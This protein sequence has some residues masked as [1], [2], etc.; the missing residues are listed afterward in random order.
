MFASAHKLPVKVHLE[1]LPRKLPVK[2][3]LG[4]LPPSSIYNIAYIHNFSIIH[5]FFLS[6]SLLQMKVIFHKKSN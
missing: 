1:L 4:L 6:T 5:E 2:V 3:H